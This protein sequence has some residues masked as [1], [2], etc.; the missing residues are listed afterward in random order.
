[1]SSLISS[2]SRFTPTRVGNTNRTACWAIPLS[3]HPHTRGEYDRANRHGG[4]RPG[5]PPHAWGIRLPGRRASSTA[6]FTP[7]RV[8]NT[9]RPGW[10]SRRGT[11][12]PHTRGEYFANASQSKSPIGSPP[13]AWGIRLD[14]VR[15]RWRMSVHPHTRGE[16]FRLLVALAVNQAVHPHTRGEYALEGFTKTGL[17]RF[18]PTRVGNT[19]SAPLQEGGEFG[20]PPH[21]WGIPQ[22][23]VRLLRWRRFTPTR[24]GNTIEPRFHQG[25][26]ARF[27]PTRV[28]NTAGIPGVVVG[29]NGSPPHAWGIRRRRRQEEE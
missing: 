3:V 5:S 25:L 17:L 21:A 12:H 26:N 15:N 27:T 23:A 18:T 28:G 19:G 2:L 13:H 20:S 16:Y 8:G 6:R 22:C 14:A 24:V 7:T 9:P 4:P 1:M 10:P 29:H 11:V